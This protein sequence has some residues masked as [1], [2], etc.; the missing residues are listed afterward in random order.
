ME[1]RAEGG[2][3]QAATVD[4]GEMPAPVVNV[5]VAEAKAAAEKEA[6]P[7]MEAAPG[8]AV[9]GLDKAAAAPAPPKESA[10][11][12]ALAPPPLAWPLA[13]P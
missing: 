11:V 2:R 1:G 8:A 3:A 12:N 4:A 10:R 9:C 13:W 6:A 7:E 5:E